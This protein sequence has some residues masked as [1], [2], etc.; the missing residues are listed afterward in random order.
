MQDPGSGWGDSMGG[1]RRTETTEAG[2]PSIL[3]KVAAVS[4]VQGVEQLFAGSREGVAEERA[5]HILRRKQAGAASVSNQ[6]RV[7]SATENPGG[8]SSNPTGSANRQRNTV[9]RGAEGVQEDAGADQL[10]RSGC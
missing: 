5:G 2:G 3:S 9:K 7:R 4:V 8:V 6:R 1:P 10:M